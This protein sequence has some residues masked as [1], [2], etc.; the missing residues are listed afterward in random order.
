[1]LYYLF[2]CPECGFLKLEPKYFKECYCP[3][4]DTRMKI[5]CELEIN[6]QKLAEVIEI[7]NIKQAELILKW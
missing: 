6:L 7:F 2:E 5:K 4:C 1:M 3:V